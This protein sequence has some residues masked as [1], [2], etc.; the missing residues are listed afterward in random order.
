MHFVLSAT[1]IGSELTTNEPAAMR[2]FKI[3]YFSKEIFC[4]VL[5]GTD[6]TKMLCHG[7][8]ELLDFFSYQAAW[9]TKVLSTISKAWKEASRI[10]QMI[11]AA[12]IYLF[13]HGISDLIC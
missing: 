10:S 6:L 4:T 13:I 12:N 3:K 7:L 8:M 9:S 5:F 2:S 11:L 1:Y